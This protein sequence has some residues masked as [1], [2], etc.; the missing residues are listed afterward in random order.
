[1]ARM[2]R[3]DERCPR[4]G[5]ADPAPIVYGMP[6]AEAG[7]AAARGDLVLGGCVVGPGGPDRLCRAC[8]HRWLPGVGDQ[9]KHP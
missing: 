2:V 1:M 9:P 7:Q 3:P 6:T 5:T 4:C 8:D